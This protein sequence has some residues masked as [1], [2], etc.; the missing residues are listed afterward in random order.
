MFLK[1]SDFFK[2]TISVRG[3]GGDLAGDRGAAA[4]TVGKKIVLFGQNR[5]T[6]WV[7]RVKIV[8]YLIS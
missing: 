7:K 1:T 5:C 8:Y 6:V 3:E 4:L 2:V